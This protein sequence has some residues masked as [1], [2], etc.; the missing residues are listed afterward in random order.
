MPTMASRNL[1]MTNEQTISWI[2]LSTAMASQVE[3]ADFNGISSIADGINHAIPTHKELQIS[4]SWLTEHGFIEKQ[5]NK[6]ILTTKGKNEYLKAS[7]KSNKVFKIWEIL[8][9]S[10]FKTDNK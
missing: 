7:S 8:E 1:I 9:F 6:Y 5:N 4:I 2:F 3:P 10:I